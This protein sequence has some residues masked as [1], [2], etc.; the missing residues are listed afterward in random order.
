MRVWTHI[1]VLTLPFTLAAASKTSPSAKNVA[2][3]KDVAPILQKNCQGCHRPG[4]IGPMP[5]LTYSD[6]RPW[7]KAIKEAVVLKRMPPWFADPAHGKWSNDVSLVQKDIDTLAAWA[8]SGAKEGNPKDLP[9]PVAF[10]E[11]WLLGKPDVELG[12]TKGFEVPA[13]GTID[14][15]Y[16]KVP[17]GFTEDK[18]VQAL[19]FRPGDPK[20]VHHLVL[21]LREPG[22]PFMAKLEPGV[23]MPAPNSAPRRQVADDGVGRIESTNGPE[24]LGTYTPGGSWQRF[25]PGQ[26]KLVKAGSDL[27]F[28][29]HY[30]ATG[31]VTL[32]RSRVGLT[33]AK[34]SPK[35]RIKTVFI[36]NRKLLIPTGA[37]NHRVDARVTLPMDATV[38]GLFPHMHVRGK[39]FEYNVTYPDG[40]TETLLK[41]PNYEFNWQLS[42]YPAQPI[43]LPKGTQIECTAWYDNSP[44]KKGNPD[45]TVDVRWGDQSWE[46]MLAGFL[47][48]AMP[49]APGATVSTGGGK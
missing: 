36:S 28:Q 5:L 16:I 44:N 49:V 25:E 30:T 39:A 6:A 22:S 38:T 37:A 4:Q 45:A 7:A 17:T 8:D 41:V 35:E 13:S 31:K 9:K 33:F 10:A 24:I 1:L 18:W 32:D 46:E 20:V 48:V 34:E 29:M 15:Q 21:F 3:A 47:D 12:L 43:R 23:P 42:Y 19:E 14:Y 2:F 40:R 11:G 26:A 27:V